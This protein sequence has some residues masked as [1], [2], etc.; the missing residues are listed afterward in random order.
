M[1]TKVQDVMTH[2]VVAVGE[3]T[4]FKQLVA[5]LARHRISAVPVVD[6]AE[7]V[8]GVVSEADLL[9]KEELRGAGRHAAPRFERHRHRVERAKAAGA[10]AR[11]LMTSPAVTVGLLATV[12]EAARLMHA[13]GVKRLPVVDVVT[14][15][16]TGIV[17]RGDLLRVFAR[18]DREIHDEVRD[19]VILRGFMMD[20]ARFVIG[21]RDGVVSLQGSCER[22]SLIPLLVRAVHGVESVVRVEDRLAYDLDDREVTVPGPWPFPRV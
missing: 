9:L 2:E 14:G 1:K 12:D 7:R 11:E 18:P 8:V 3:S 10:V 13:H 21:V 4:P 17:T 6:A 22:R 5:L 15:R 16:L 19:Q 20:P